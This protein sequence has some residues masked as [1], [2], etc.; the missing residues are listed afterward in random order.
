MANRLGQR[1]HRKASDSRSGAAMPIWR[2][3]RRPAFFGSSRYTS[4]SGSRRAPG[5]NSTGCAPPCS[6]WSSCLQPLAGYARRSSSA[7]KLASFF[8]VLDFKAREKDFDDHLGATVLVELGVPSQRLP[9]PDRCSHDVAFSSASPHLRCSARL[10]R[11]R[12]AAPVGE[13]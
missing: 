12:P 4:F 10:A 5:W 11:K 8:E 7:P 1:P 3:D 6:R 2:G 13:A 9:S